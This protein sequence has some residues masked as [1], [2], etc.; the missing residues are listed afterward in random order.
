MGFPLHARFAHPDAGWTG[1]GKMAAEHLTVGEVYTVRTLEVG[2]SSSVLTLYEV[3]G[4]TFNTVLFE[5]DK[6]PGFLDD[7]DD[8]EDDV[9]P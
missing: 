3:P 9:P 7:D 6:G 1:E 5:A 4:Q 2:R 8:D